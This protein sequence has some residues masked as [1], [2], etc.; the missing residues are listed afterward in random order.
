MSREELHDLAQKD[1]PEG[2]N[3]PNSWRGLIS[4]A[5]IR[6][7]VGILI[8]VVFGLMLKEVYR[9]MRADRAELFQAYVK[10]AEAFS[11]H[12]SAMEGMTREQEKQ[13]RNVEL[14]TEAIKQQTELIKE[15]VRSQKP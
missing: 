4:W 12:A 3:I 9:D 13:N 14:Q 6:F 15:L 5:V 1:S 11:R 7:G 10:S 2:V 8:A